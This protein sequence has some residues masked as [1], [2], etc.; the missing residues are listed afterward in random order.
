MTN[1]HH[2]HHSVTHHSVPGLGRARLTPRARA[3]AALVC[4]GGLSTLAAC[5]GDG[6]AAADDHAEAF[7]AQLEDSTELATAF[8]DPTTDTA[9]IVDASIDSQRW[10]PPRSERTSGSSSTR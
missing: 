2:T 10:L 1:A 5:S 6:A 3:V 8:G 4:L 7:C 9:D